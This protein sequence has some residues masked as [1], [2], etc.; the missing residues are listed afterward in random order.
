MRQ[1]CCRRGQSESRRHVGERFA[2]RREIGG[3]KNAVSNVAAEKNASDT[4]LRLSSSQ[5]FIFEKNFKDYRRTAECCIFFNLDEAMPSFRQVDF[6]HSAEASEKLTQR[7]TR[8]RGPEETTTN[9]NELRGILKPAG[10]SLRPEQKYFGARA[11]A[12]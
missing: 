3:I 1:G 5:I 12:A 7:T 8:A 4:F 11:G 2:K 9:I 6:A 10:G